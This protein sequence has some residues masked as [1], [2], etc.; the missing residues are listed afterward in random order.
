MPTETAPSRPPVECT[1]GHAHHWDKDGKR[2]VILDYET[3]RYTEMRVEDIALVCF[4][5]RCGAPLL[6]RLA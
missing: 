4:C 6:D 5:G 3:K 2:Y 1:A